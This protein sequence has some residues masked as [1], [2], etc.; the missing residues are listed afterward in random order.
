MLAVILEATPI[1]QSPEYDGTK[2]LSRIRL[3]FLLGIVVDDFSEKR[4]RVLFVVPSWAFLRDAK[5]VQ[6][7]S[8]GCT[9]DST[10]AWNLD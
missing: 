10:Y 5:A 9:M 2:R 3:L 6:Y 4:Y 8:R 7:S 1:P